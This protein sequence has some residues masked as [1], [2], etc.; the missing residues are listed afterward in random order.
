MEQSGGT[1]RWWLAVEALPRVK[2]DVVVV[3]AGGNECGPFSI[4]L[5]D[6]KA[7][8]TAVKTEGPFDICDL[9]V[10]M[11]NGSPWINGRRIHS[12]NFAMVA[13]YANHLLCGPHQPE[14][15]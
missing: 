10:D 11:A 3:A 2:A 6:L 5:R 12:G 8:D 13:E 9:Q 4:P 15:H 14:D 1:R 7:Q